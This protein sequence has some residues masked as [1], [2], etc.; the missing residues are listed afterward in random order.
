[1]TG[2]DRD[3][4]D[5]GWADGGVQGAHAI[6]HSITGLKLCQQSGVGVGEDLV[7][8]LPPLMA[9]VEDA[10]HWR[11]QLRPCQAFVHLVGPRSVCI[12]TPSVYI[13]P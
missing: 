10:L 3:L 9:Q 11:L 7:I 8:L 12:R 13:K 1:M 5:E 2:A 6:Q 4:Q